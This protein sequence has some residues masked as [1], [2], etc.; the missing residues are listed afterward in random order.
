VFYNQYVEVDDSTNFYSDDATSNTQND[1]KAR[2]E[3][4]K[5]TRNDGNKVNGEPDKRC[6]KN[7]KY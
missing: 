3:Y 1:K 4:H 2:K 6:S 7:P 5:P